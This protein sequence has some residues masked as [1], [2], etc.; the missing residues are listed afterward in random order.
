M[1]GIIG[2]V[3]QRNVTTILIE[4]LHR[5][6]YRGYDS[7]G[8]AIYNAKQG[9]QRQ[10]AVG[11]IDK[12][13]NA[14]KT[15]PL[16]GNIGIAH[17][18]W[19]T[20]GA[21][22]ENN[23][24]PH[25]SND[26]IALVHNGIIENFYELRD[27]LKSAGY[28]F[29]SDTDTET[30]AHSI[31]RY[32]DSGCDFLTAVQQTVKKLSGG[33]ALAIMHSK[34][35]DKIIVVRSGSPIVIGLGIEEN[36]I[37]SDTIA[38]LPVTRQ[39]IYL[40][41]GDI[42]VIERT[43]VTI[44]NANLQIV[45]RPIKSSEITND[46]TDRGIYRHYMQKEIFE[47]PI[48]IADTILERLTDN[49]VI[50]EAFGNNAKEIFAKTK[51]I[52]IVACGS[53]YHAA[54]TGRYWIENFA[55]I[56]CKVEVA[57]ELR[58]RNVAIEPN[59]LL[60]TMSQSGET[61]DTLAA[62]RQSKSLPYIANLTICNVPESSLVR[63]SDLVFMTRAGPE[64]GVATTKA[65]TAQLVGLLMLTLALR[66]TPAA[67]EADLVKQ[68][69]TLPH[70]IEQVL[71]LDNKIMQIAE[72]IAP[73][74]NVF[75]LGRGI[76]YPIAMEGSLKLKEISYIH[77]EAYPAGELKHGPLA[78]IDKNVPVIVI[79]SNDELLEK[80][81]SNLYEI[82]ARGGELVIFTDNNVNLPNRPD[83]IVLRLPALH[84]IIAPIIYTIPLQLLSYHVA[85]LRGT[86]VDRPRN[87]AK[88]VTV[89]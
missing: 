78:L 19:A 50:A 75:F 35:P 81:K 20:H 34:E 22:T 64:V 76:N 21:P 79:V 59:T 73:K 5:L 29:N 18:R 80:I 45:T 40:E 51:C 48:A 54:L 4:C 63:E 31:H 2:A 41:E 43:A 57:S 23:A 36:F 46:S 25:I 3:S 87:L 42:A 38:L 55:G 69:K 49:H 17:T 39:F 58:Y 68:L 52:Q 71:A 1:C 74:N 28:I 60:V 66:K 15:N 10:R 77:A 12:L 11:K 44:Y 27:E 53:S 9:L 8:I 72:Y 70:L 89:E 13:S 37:A 14:L 7:A 24:H 32:C 6:E 26:T 33:Y 56:P 82:S 47:Q 65:F 62:L 83:W 88:S 61:A 30:I 16:F 85:I 86:D 67:I 84:P